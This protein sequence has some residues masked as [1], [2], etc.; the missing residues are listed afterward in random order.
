MATTKPVLYVYLTPATKKKLDAE[1]T[2]RN[3]MRS[4]WDQLK[5]TQLVE[6]LLDRVLPT[7]GL[8]QA[9]RCDRAPAKKSPKRTPAKKAVRK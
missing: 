6:E 4:A 3:K 7:S 5:R 1:L 9:P 8:V 2:R